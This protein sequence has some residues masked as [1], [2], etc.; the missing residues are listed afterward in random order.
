MSSLS[1]ITVTSLA[2]P[3][4]EGEVALLGIYGLAGLGIA[5]FTPSVLSLVAD[6][7]TTGRTGQA[8][9]WYSTAHYGAIAIGPFLGGLVAQWSSYRL[10]F[11]ASAGVTGIAMIVGLAVPA[12]P[13]AHA[14]SRSIARLADLRGNPAVWAGWIA[15]V[16]GL[17]IQGTVFTFL[18]LLASGHT[19]TPSALVFLILGLSNTLARF[20]AAWLIDR[21]GRPAPCAVAGLLVASAVATLSPHTAAG[22]PLL[23]LA[24]PFGG[25]SGMAFVAI[26]TALA[27]AATAATRGLVMGG[28]ST[29]TSASPSAHLA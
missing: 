15:A 19:L 7:A 27:G 21:T 5:A 6:T 23:V 8:Y 10:A 3:Y 4:A 29:C 16:A 24:A 28:Y 17:L 14:G 18:P 2:L 22:V 1:S 20:P 11:L 12:A 26:S 25:V 9:A 13:P